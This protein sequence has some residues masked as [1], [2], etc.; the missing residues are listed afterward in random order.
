MVSGKIKSLEAG[1]YD[2][3][4]EVIKAIEESGVQDGV[5]VVFT[6]DSTASVMMTSKGDP[7]I[8]EDFLEDYSRI[9]PARNNF[10]YKGD[11][12]KAAAHSKSALAGVSLDIIIHEG[13]ALL[14]KYQQIVLADF[15]GDK[16][17]TWML[18]C[19]GKK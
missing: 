1:V 6:P 8:Y 10:E 16:E 11:V 9:F 3:T 15:L 4:G 18:Q 14:G 12:E 17:C 7:R 19:I 2:I 13:K 5:C